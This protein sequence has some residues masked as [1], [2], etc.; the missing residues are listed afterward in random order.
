[1]D[2]R[3]V[4]RPKLADTKLKKKSLII[5]LIMLLVSIA[6]LAG[7][8]ISLNILP[9]FNKLKGEVTCTEIPARFRPYD[10]ETNPE[11]LHEY[12]FTDI[13]FYSAVISNY[14]SY[15]ED[16]TDSTLC[17]TI[18]E[19]QL[20]TIERLYAENKGI[21]NL[22]GIEYL[23][24]TFKSFYIPNNN[25]SGELDLTD[26]NFNTCS[27]GI[28]LS[29]NKLTSVKFG[30]AYCV[31][32]VDL[33]NNE[34]ESITFGNFATG[35][36]D[37]SNNK[38]TYVDLSDVCKSIPSFWSNPH[39]YYNLA[40]NNLTAESIILPKYIS[41]HSLNLINNKISS[42]SLVG[43]EELYELDLHYNPLSDIKY[44]LKGKKIDYHPLV[45]NDKYQLMYSIDNENV[46]TY[47]DGVISAV[48]EGVTNLVISNNEIESMH[49]I[50]VYLYTK[51]G[52]CG[53]NCDQEQILNEAL[54]KFNI[55][56]D[57]LMNIPET[58][59]DIIIQE[60]KVYDIESDKYSIDKTKKEISYT[61]E[62]NVED[63][64]LTLEDL[65]GVI[66]GDNYIIKDGETIVDTYKLVN[67]KKE[68]VKPSNNET[69]NKVVT[70]TKKKVN[71]KNNKVINETTT[72]SKITLNEE[73][74]KI[75]NKIVKTTTKKEI[76]ETKKKCYWW[77]L[78]LLILPI[79][80]YI[81]YKKDK[82]N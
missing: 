25:I 64:E 8:L 27:N 4:G 82:K 67:V 71:R 13:N 22:E 16:N 81:V 52:E 15:G 31:E 39:S 11:G 65:T 78:L 21:N 37:L 77:L 62:L 23:N 51:M 54:N 44:I 48:D 1:M 72:T 30:D 32:N 66:E 45:L 18:T 33:N 58:T 74:K 46:A 63:I 80:G 55:T 68:E 73:Q 49:P 43:Q 6:L 20:A 76:K 40:Y 79:V 42:I 56:M 59:N 9:K 57:D 69:D 24:H 61:G 10:A 36:I 2:N 34:L 38:L 19:E 53:N 28:D 75:I 35:D 26:F 47:N 70:T 3:K 41:T 60:I 5:S 29:N 50:Y 12:G 7:G 17:N 14:N